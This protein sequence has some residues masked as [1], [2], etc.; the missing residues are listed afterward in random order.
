MRSV[1]SVP[2]RCLYC[3]VASK[4]S[5]ELVSPD[6]WREGTPKDVKVSFEKLPEGAYAADAL[7]FSEAEAEV[8]RTPSNVRDGRAPRP[9][10]A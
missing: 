7:C 6:I 5:A 2:W 4:S 8:D 10:Q 9:H 1:A 3:Y